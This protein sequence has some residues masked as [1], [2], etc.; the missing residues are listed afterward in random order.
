[1]AS[2]DPDKA[3][4]ALLGL[5]VG[6]ALG[7]GEGEGAPA[8]QMAFRLADSLIAQ[9][10][11]DGDDVLRSYVAWYG[12]KPAGIDPATAAV[13]TQIAAGADAY[14]AT[15]THH[16]AIG[17][18]AAGNSALTRATPVAIAFAKHP[19]GLRDATLADAALTEYDP[20]PGKAA[21]LA[22][23]SVALLIGPGPRALSNSLQDPLPFDDRLQDVVLPAIGGVRRVAEQAAATHPHLVTTPIAVAFAAYFTFDSF[24][25]GVSWA[26]NLGG[27]AA[28]YGA[29]TGALL[30]ARF[31]ASHVPPQWADALDSRAQVDRLHAG[32][33]ALAG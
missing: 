6:E 9:G 5:A 23:Q 20:L 8:T 11:Y 15:S 30:G 33:V 21:L 16:A 4:G 28:G 1:M 31:G 22:N 19:E 3:L 14:R 13:L 25:Q 18:A 29:V 32:L 10:G 7:R 26:V 27:D 17:G 2:I 24:E 12:T